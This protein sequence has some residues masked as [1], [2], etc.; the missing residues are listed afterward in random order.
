MHK[1]DLNNTHHGII[2]ANS[3]SDISILNVKKLNEKQRRNL[4][5]FSSI[6]VP[7]FDALYL[8]FALLNSSPLNV[9]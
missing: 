3:S 2:L 1:L 4:L 6:R 9:I 7:R 5:T 8:N